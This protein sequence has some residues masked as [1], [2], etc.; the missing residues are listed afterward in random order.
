[1][2][3]EESAGSLH[4]LETFRV[5]RIVAAQWV[6]VSTVGFFAF[7]YLFAGVRAWIR[8]RPLEPIVLPISTHPTT[9]ELLGGFGLLVALV[10]ALHEAIHG[11]AM[12]VFGREPTYGFGL[13]HVVVPYAYA[14]SD[15]GY[16]RDQ[17][18]AVLLAP[19]VGISA[20]GVL[21]MS[22]Y[23]SPVLV[24]ALAANAAGS[25]GDLWMASILLRFPESVCVG[26][27]PD[28]APDGRGMG[29][30]GSSAS[31]GRVTVR[32]RLASAF[33]V[34]AV[35]ALVLL[36]IGMVGTVLLSL[37]LGTG[38]VVV[39]DPYG[40]WFL[41]AHELSRG[42]RQVRLRIGVEVIL[43]AMSLGGGLWTVTVGGVELLR[44]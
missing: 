43:T 33:L 7:G 21:V 32:S 11:L 19:V 39:G 23:P 44:S 4:T 5:T 13:S 20:L 40:R 41:F 26:P 16:T 38:T 28:R 12:S 31:Q 37:A 1:M 2:S 34:G 25:I 14:N 17:M 24:V 9:L 29:I 30:Y 18:L 15:G 8:G 42:T 35:G 36:V 3:A 27:L 6:V 10:I 22:A